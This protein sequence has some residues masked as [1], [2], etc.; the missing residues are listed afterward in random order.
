M[1]SKKSK[2][3]ALKTK[4][5]QQVF[6]LALAILL[7]IAMLVALCMTCKVLRQQKAINKL[8]E[9][10]SKTPPE[11]PKS[12]PGNTIIQNN[13]PTITLKIPPK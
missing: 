10:A 4:L 9:S 2:F 8:R 3:C 5:L 12:W 11:E 1:Q 6:K 7:L 13:N